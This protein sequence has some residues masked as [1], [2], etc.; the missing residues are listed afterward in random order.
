MRFRRDRASPYAFAVTSGTPRDQ[1]K[2]RAQLREAA[3]ISDQTERLLECAAIVDEALSEIGVHPVVV[4]G[5][6]VAYWLESEYTTVDIDVLMPSN[7]A[8]DE[9]MRLLGFEKQGRHWLLPGTNVAFEAP[10][11]TLEPGAK[12][13]RVELRSGRTLTLLRAEDVL[14]DRLNQFHSGGHRDVF[15]QSIALTMLPLDMKTV[16]DRARAENIEHVLDAVAALGERVQ[17]GGSFE[18]WELHE[19]ARG[20]RDGGLEKEADADVP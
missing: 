20:L 15:E 18:T 6:A 12:G 14:I 3:R 13:E 7:P 4:G 2:R 1:A 9:Q 8:V 17:R 5:L 16:R 11:W 19:I 10:G